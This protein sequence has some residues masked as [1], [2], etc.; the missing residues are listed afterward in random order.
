V[1]QP[2]PMLP[3]GAEAHAWITR[4]STLAAGRPPIITLAD[5]FTIVPGAGKC[6][7]GNGRGQGTEKSVTRDAGLP[8]ISTVGQPFTIT[9]IAGRCL[10]RSPILA[11]GGIFSLHISNRSYR[12]IFHHHQCRRRYGIFYSR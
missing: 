4:S 11:A 7:C 5:P 9:S 3:V 10:I 2:V 6:P 8:P 12:R 1:E